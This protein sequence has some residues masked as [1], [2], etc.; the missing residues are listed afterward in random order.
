MEVEQHIRDAVDKKAKILLGG[1]HGSGPAMR[2]TMVVVSPSSDKAATGNSFEPTI[3]TD[4][5][6]SMKIAHEE[7]FGRVAALFR[8]FNEDDVIAR[9]NDTDVGL[10]SYIMTNDLARAYRVAAQLPD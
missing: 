2:F 10:A 7:I 5:N 4:A 8:F 9:S 6:Q 1:K 3:L